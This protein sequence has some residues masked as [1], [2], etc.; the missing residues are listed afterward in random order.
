[1]TGCST[2][3]AVCFVQSASPAE[4]AWET[5]GGVGYVPPSMAP[6]R[7]P[8]TARTAS[9]AE[10]RHRGYHLVA[11]VRT[12]TLLRQTD[13]SAASGRSLILQHR[14]SQTVIVQHR[15]SRTLEVQHQVARH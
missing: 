8:A 9:C 5:V 14:V 12:V 4:L 10:W 7:V 15:A 2:H 11:Q 6:T 1:M 13:E 3:P